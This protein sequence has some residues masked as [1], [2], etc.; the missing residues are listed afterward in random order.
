MVL[1]CLRGHNISEVGRYKGGQCRACERT[2]VREWKQ[3][4][5]AHVLVYA[6]AYA[7]AY[8]AVGPRKA[9]EPFDDIYQ[10]L[11]GR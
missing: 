4:N 6:R 2:R 3:Q 5:R 7:K 1:F 9:A 11:L 10:L 8:R